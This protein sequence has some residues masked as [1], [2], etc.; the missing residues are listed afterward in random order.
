VPKFSLEEKTMPGFEFIE[1]DGLREKAEAALTTKM[2]ELTSSV[3]E[4]IDEAVAGLK[5][6]NE[7]LIGEKKSIQERL[8]EFSDITDPIKAMEALNFLTENE[9]A[10]LIKDGKIEEVIEKRTSQLRLDHETALEEFSIKIQD[11]ESSKGKYKSMFQNKIIEDELRA[12][13]A[14]QGVRMEALSDV[15]LR[16]NTVFTL[17]SDGSVEARDSSGALLKNEK[18][19]VLTPAVWIDGLKDSSPHYWPI[20]EGAGATGKVGNS[21]DTL[22]KLNA[23]AERGDMEGFRKLRAKMM[24]K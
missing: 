20:S 11:L 19:S 12:V 24:G 6:K 2:E 8:S 14:K 18:G 13:A 7:E 3:D 4:K 10:K 21:T 22:D 1:D 9:D 5:A 17:G 23:L 15:L 16:G